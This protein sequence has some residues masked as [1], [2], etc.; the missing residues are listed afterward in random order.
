M[1]RRLLVVIL[2]AISVWAVAVYVIAHVVP[3]DVGARLGFFGTMVLFYPTADT[4]LRKWLH[5][6]NAGSSNGHPPRAAAPPKT[7]SLDAVKSY[8]D[9]LNAEAIS[10]FSVWHA[11]AYFLGLSMIGLGFATGTS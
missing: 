11:V 5:A 9:K 3:P 2:S 10:L 4:E 6:R 8:I 1:P 7:V